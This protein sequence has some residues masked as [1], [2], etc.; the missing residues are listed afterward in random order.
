MSRGERSFFL[1]IFPM[2]YCLRWGTGLG[3]HVCDEWQKKK[4]NEER[5]IISSF[6]L[7]IIY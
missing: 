5:T 4:V 6:D 2:K 3:V 1:A 7:Y